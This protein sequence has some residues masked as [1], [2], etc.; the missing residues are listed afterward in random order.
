M[1]FAPLDLAKCLKEPAP[2]IDFVLPGLPAR[3]VGALVAPGASG[4]TFFAL[5]IAAALALGIPVAGGALP[6]PANAGKTVLIAGEE[7]APMLVTRLHALVDWLVGM[8]Q[9]LPLEEQFERDAV[10]KRLAEQLVVYPLAGLSM[11][12]LERGRTT[13]TLGTIAE[14]CAGARLLIVDP[15]R[16]FH[17]GDENDSNDMTTVV[18]AFEAVAH[19]AG[20]AV[21][22]THHTNKSATLSG[23][24]DAQ[25][26][27]RGSSALTDAIRWQANLVGMS[28]VEAERFGVEPEKRRYYVRLEHAKPNYTEPQP[29]VW[30]RRQPGGCLQRVELHERRGTRGTARGARNG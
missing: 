1:S 29:G 28:E 26:A 9:F 21:L 23:N 17:G 8:S 30:M 25:Q 13:R 18:Q 14:A 5:Q 22:L 12:V 20:C 10:I 16:R 15:L 7:S 6:A 11:R 2:K 19:Q 27:I 3:A 24:G 4:K